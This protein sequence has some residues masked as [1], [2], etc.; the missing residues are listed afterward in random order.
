MSVSDNTV[1]GNEIPKEDETEE[2]PEASEQPPVPTENSD[3][4]YASLMAEQEKSSGL[5]QEIRDILERHFQSVND[6]KVVESETISSN[7]VLTNEYRQQVS[8]RLEEVQKAIT[9]SKESIS[10]NSIP[11]V[12]VSCNA[13]QDEAFTKDI[14][15]YMSKS[16]QQL[17]EISLYTKEKY[18]AQSVELAGIGLI[19][20]ILLAV[21][22]TRWFKHG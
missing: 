14:T 12:T 6:Q 20:G 8:D 17:A 2:I 13:V 11:Q 15:E 1:S 10:G 21:S 5:L 19:A 9:E 4:E 18:S 22:F 16:E 7:A 3:S